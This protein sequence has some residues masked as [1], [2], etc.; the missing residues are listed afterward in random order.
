MDQFSYLA[1]NFL[2]LL[3]LMTIKRPLAQ[4]LH[5][6]AQY[7]KF[8]SNSANLRISGRLDR[9]RSQQSHWMWSVMPEMVPSS[10]K[11][12][13]TAIN[14]ISQLRDAAKINKG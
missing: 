11:H 6:A 9:N 2:S 12:P 1:F 13:Q 10:G 5:E 4:S 7:L 14:Q 8:L 3:Q